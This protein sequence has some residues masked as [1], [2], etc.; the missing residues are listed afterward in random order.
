METVKALLFDVFGTVVDWRT[1][2]IREGEALARRHGWP[3]ERV[4]W[5]AFAGEW[6]RTGYAGAI[7]RIVQGEEPW[8]DVDTLHRR[9]LDELIG[10][11]GLTDLTEG[12][13]ERFNRVWHRLTPWPDAVLGLTRLK[14]RYVVA[15][16]SNGNLALLTNMAKHAALPWDCILSA[17]LFG[18]YK[19]APSVYEG[20]VRLLRLQ[21]WEVMM[22]AAHAGDLRAAQATGMRTAYVHRPLEFGLGGETTTMPAPDAFDVVAGDFI[23]LA[24]RLET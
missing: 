19:P 7:R 3:P 17:E 10:T 9:K 13:I 18:A 12:D 4:D 23:A 15:P 1:S 11:Y 24:E 2:V 5:G 8:A 16:L 6:R 14:R 22:V 21:P 20:A